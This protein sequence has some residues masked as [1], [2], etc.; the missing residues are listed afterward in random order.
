MVPIPAQVI[1]AVDPVKAQLLT[2]PNLVVLS[3]G[4]LQTLSLT[5]T[6]EFLSAFTFFT[7][8][9]STVVFF[10]PFTVRQV[11]PVLKE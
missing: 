11:P 9:G 7:G 10:S 4:L 1:A 5:T 8:D 6:K 2:K 3:Q